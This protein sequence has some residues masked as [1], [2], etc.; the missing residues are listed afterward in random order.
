M[1]YIELL[2]VFYLHICVA[3]YGRSLSPFCSDVVFTPR[4]CCAPRPGLRCTDPGAAR[5]PTHCGPRS[6]HCAQPRAALGLGSPAT[7]LFPGPLF[8]TPPPRGSLSSLPGALG[9]RP[10]SPCPGPA[11]APSPPSAHPQHRLLPV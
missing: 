1:Y 7:P 11:P 5:V 3:S 4:M 8:P 2:S 9:P 10:S 6:P